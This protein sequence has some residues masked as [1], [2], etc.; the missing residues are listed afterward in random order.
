M[1]SQM[2]LAMALAGI[3]STAGAA[4]MPHWR[5]GTAVS[6]KADGSPVTQADEAAEAI[7]IGG[8]QTLLP[9][10]PIVAEEAI[11]RGA[12]PPAVGDR[13]LLVD[14]LDGTKEF[15]S[16][17]GEFTV[18]IALI[19]AGR[20]VLGVVY[21]PALSRMYVGADVALRIE[22]APGRDPGTARSWAISVRKADAAQLTA[23]ASK[24]HRDAETDA[25]LARIGAAHLSSIGSS[26]KFCLIAEGA[27]DVYPR[28]GPT[29][30]WDTAAGQAVLLSA[31]GV[32]A[33][34]NGAP[35][36]YGK[37][38][39]GFRNPGF[40]AWGDSAVCIRG[41]GRAP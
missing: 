4:I 27:A 8:L 20:P 25:F 35:F 38:E 16:G 22:V 34:P 12:E 6:E 11:A 17:S 2:D 21:A 14:P 39:H 33:K 10:V 23:V 1:R 24:S 41:Q 18:N 19:E 29:M 15:V 26:L 31:R 5:A 3:A 28:F 32:V 13:F 37:S 40:I 30:E 36:L 9:G 7:I